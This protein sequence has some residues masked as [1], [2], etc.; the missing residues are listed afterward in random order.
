MENKTIL[1]KLPKIK[2]V[3]IKNVSLSDLIKTTVKKNYLK[4]YY[5]YTIP[6]KQVIV[7]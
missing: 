6:I 3:F 7:H 2:E 4:Y 1:L 5:H